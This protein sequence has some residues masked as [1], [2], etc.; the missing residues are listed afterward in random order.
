MARV[1]SAEVALIIEYNTTKVTDLTPFITVADLLID[2]VIDDT[3]LDSATLKEI[4]RWLSAHFLEVSRNRE[5]SSQSI[6]GTS[7]SY[8]T[9]PDF[10]LRLTRYG[11][12]AITLDTTGALAAASAGK[13]ASFDLLNP[14]D[15]HP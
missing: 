4:S 6:D 8:S 3:L 15:E 7:E 10:G 13:K 9:K 14:I 11:Q 2:N 12:M 1:T 5:K